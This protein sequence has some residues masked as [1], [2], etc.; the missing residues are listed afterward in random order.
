M[1]DKIIIVPVCLKNINTVLDQLNLG[2]IHQRRETNIIKATIVAVT[3]K[4][5]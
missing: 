5:G 1:A 4:E 2:F 3:Y